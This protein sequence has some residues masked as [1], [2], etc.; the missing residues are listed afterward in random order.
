MT[1]FVKIGPQINKTLLYLAPLFVFPLIMRIDYGMMH[2]V[3]IP[4]IVWTTDRIT[5]QVELTLAIL[6]WN[7]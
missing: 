6:L 7:K 1:S 5:H 2:L 4:M 3:I